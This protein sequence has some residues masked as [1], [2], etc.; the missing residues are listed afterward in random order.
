MANDTMG[1]KDGLNGYIYNS[2][3]CSLLDLE[4]PKKKSTPYRIPI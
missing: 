1:V 4:N 3:Y 2:A